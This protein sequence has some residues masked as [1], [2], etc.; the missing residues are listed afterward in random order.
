VSPSPR[1]ALALGV[2][3][4]ATAFLGVGFGVLAALVLIGATVA[5]ALAV[6]R[7][8]EVRRSVAPILARGVRSPLRVATDLQGGPGTVRVRQPV[9]P[10]LGLAPR[11]GT[12]GLEA[13]LVPLRRGRQ[14]LPPVAARRDGPLGLGRRHFKA[15][16]EPAE[17]LVYPD[18]PAARRLALAVRAGRF[19]DAG[20]LTRGPLGLGTDFE[21][22]REYAPDDDVRQVNWRATQ[23]MQ[24]PMSNQYRVEQDREVMLLLDSGR[25]ME[26]PLQPDPGAP[27]RNGPEV[28]SGP[29]TRLDAA[30]DA[31]VSVALVADAVGD[32]CGTVA[33]AAGLRRR[34]APRRAGGDA[35]V[36]ALFDLEPE[37]AE[38]DYEL[39]FRTVAGAKRSLIVIFTD[40][41]E[42]SAARPLID[43]VPV[44]ARR[45]AVVIAT[46]TDLDLEAVLRADP[47]VPRD[48][49][50]AAIALEVL[51]AR[52]RTVHRLEAT[53]A[54][55]VEARAGAL[56][57][58]CVRAYLGAKA[59]A[60]L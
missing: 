55:V 6:R 45:H 31:A 27:G 12:G 39:A 25:L 15:T 11:E 41:L 13:E 3:A 20:R 43:A 17:V 59:A 40:L 22:I 35:V 14:A 19:R 47:R 1:A 52:R 29:Q 38:P 5:D 56:G 34:I 49:Y 7:T 18:L 4:I 26:A 8:P 28:G 58:A 32:R 23:R 57:A 16:T 53:G 46:A 50:A 9:A 30:V 21:S 36:R 2:I 33:F 60:R 54:R 48:V 51:A 37:P 24:R 44:L 10:D 42:E